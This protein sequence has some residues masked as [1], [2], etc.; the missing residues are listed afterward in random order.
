MPSIGPET[1]VSLQLVPVG[2]IILFSFPTAVCYNLHCIHTLIKNLSIIFF[3]TFSVQIHKSLSNKTADN[4]TIYPTHNTSKRFKFLHLACIH[5]TVGYLV[6]HFNTCLILNWTSS[7]ILKCLCSLGFISKLQK[8]DLGFHFF[9]FF[10]VWALSSLYILIFFLSPV[11]F[12]TQSPQ[13]C[14][15]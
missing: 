15:Q 3:L 10:R 2:L 13:I 1:A 6:S 11:A 9:F 5:A 4:Y 7:F 14:K 12:L 8:L